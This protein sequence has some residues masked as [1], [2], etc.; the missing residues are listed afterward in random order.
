MEKVSRRHRDI[1]MKAI[2]DYYSTCP[3]PN[4]HYITPKYLT[5]HGLA[6]SIDPERVV[7]VLSAMG[8]ISAKC[9][10]MEKQRKITLTN[11]GICYFENQ[12]DQRAE[13]RSR[14][15]H[16][17]LIAIFSAMAG[18]IASEPLWRFLHFVWSQWKA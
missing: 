15:L 8:Y 10:P 2:I 13:R 3:D 1:A 5:H 9:P 12:A 18:A 17:W 4:T 11:A 16:D 6:A 14:R 7:D